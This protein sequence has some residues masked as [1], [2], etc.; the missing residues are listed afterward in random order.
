MFVSHFRPLIWRGQRDTLL[1]VELG[2][3]QNAKFLIGEPARDL[4]L[5]KGAG[6][7][8]IV[9]CASAL[10][11]VGCLNNLIRFRKNPDASE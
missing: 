8:L 3:E 6:E 2:T 11:N 10:T 7:V 9:F 4:S 1:C 5:R